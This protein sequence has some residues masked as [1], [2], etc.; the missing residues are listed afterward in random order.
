MNE[1]RR[2]MSV[3]TKY[4]GKFHVS[5]SVNLKNTRGLYWSYSW[6]IWP[7]FVKTI[8]YFLLFLCLLYLLPSL[9]SFDEIPPGTLFSKTSSYID[10]NILFLQK[11]LDNITHIDG[12]AEKSCKIYE[13]YHKVHLFFLI[14]MSP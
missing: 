8:S 9:L 1:N 4:M 3:Y 14:K 10:N 13:I 5:Q 6:Q 12:E 11:I 7:A 2:V